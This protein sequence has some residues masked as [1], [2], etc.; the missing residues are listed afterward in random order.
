MA[1]QVSAEVRHE[2][3]VQEY[4]VVKPFLDIFRKVRVAGHFIA[5]GIA[6]VTILKFLGI[7]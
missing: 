5:G 4:K 6:L 7:F 2:T 3:R 1:G